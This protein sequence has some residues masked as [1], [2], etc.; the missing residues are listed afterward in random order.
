[1]LSIPQPPRDMIASLRLLAET[2]PQ[3]IGLI[4][5]AEHGEARF[6]YA[7]ID[8][9]ARALGAYFQTA[10]ASGERALLL[11]D[12]GIEYITAFFGCLYAGVIAVPVYPPEVAR[13]QHL[14]R[15]RAIAADAEARYVLTTTTLAEK[16]ADARAAM[17]PGATIVAI[18][19]LDETTA[20]DWVLHTPAA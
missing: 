17:A 7:D 11:M 5:V 1:M 14:D 10:R 4:I 15:L 2:R 18:D 12:S 3:G 19:A 8:R 16:L 20:N 9:R 6:A 13:A